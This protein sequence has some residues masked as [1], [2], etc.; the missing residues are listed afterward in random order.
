MQRSQ[1]PATTAEHPVC[2]AP[3]PEQPAML[4]AAIGPKEN[5]A[6][7]FAYRRCYRVD[8]QIVVASMLGSYLPLRDTIYIYLS[9]VFWCLD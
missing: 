6:W 1:F 2:K 3:F 8:R 5:R 9:H 7:P 4:V